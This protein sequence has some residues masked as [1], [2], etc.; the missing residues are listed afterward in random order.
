METT[1]RYSGLRAKNKDGGIEGN[2]QENG[3]YFVI[4]GLGQM[5][6]TGV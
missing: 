4:Q 6:H 2:G 5:I 3:N 1:T